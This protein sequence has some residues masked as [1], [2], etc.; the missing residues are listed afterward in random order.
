M[1]NL[2]RPFVIGQL[3]IVVKEA[4]ID[5]PK[6]YHGGGYSFEH[7][8]LEPGTMLEYVGTRYVGSDSVYED[9]FR[10]LTGPFVGFAGALPSCWGSVHEEYIDHAPQVMGTP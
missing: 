8:L 4:S 6:Y 10:V 1:P 3:F 7:Q 2:K 5:R 9:V